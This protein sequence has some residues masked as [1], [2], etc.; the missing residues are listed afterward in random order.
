MTKVVHLQNTT[1]SAGGVVP[2]LHKAFIN[3]GIESWI[4]TLKSSVNDDDHT[5]TMGR[6][7]KIKSRIDFRLQQ[8]LNRKN[9]KV[10]G[11]YSSPI[12]GSDVTSVKQVKEAD[13]IYVHWTQG[14]FMN[15]RNIEQ[16]LK[17]NKPVVFFMHDMWSL[18]GGC[19]YSFGCDKY[20]SLCSN[21]QVLP[22][23]SE[24]DRATRQFNHKL[25]LYSKY[26]N[27]IFVTPSNW[28]LSC[29]KASRVAAG[30]PSYWIPN[31]ISTDIFKPFDKKSAKT[32]LN[33]DPETTVISFGAVAVKSPY[34]GWSYLKEA[35]EKLKNIPGMPKMLILIFGGEFSEADASQLPFETKYVGLLR[36]EFSTSLV[37]NASDVFVAP[38]LADNLPTTILQ[39]LHCGTPVVG[40][41]IGGIP[42]MIK[43][44]LNGFLSKYKDAADL[45]KGIEYCIT[46]KLNATIT[47]EFDEKTI[48]NQHKELINSLLR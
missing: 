47:P 5:L 27:L 11:L 2:K 7:A 30:K 44:N 38:S 45:A 34:K 39:S 13:V 41:D 17:L 32:F 1:E 4:L 26:N 25:S 15:L 3:N 48:I 6:S 10:F 23:N 40:F 28:L 36:D 31:I 21:C 16:L 18:T 35:L 8:Y 19:H 33:I 29:V 20:K 22:G 42:D 9:S 24:T 12:L 37:Y 14:G 46:H 43:H